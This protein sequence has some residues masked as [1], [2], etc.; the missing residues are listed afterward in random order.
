MKD[1]GLKVHFGRRDGIL[2]GEANFNQE[3][4]IG[5]RSITGSLDKG[6]PRKEIIFVEHE[7]ELIKFLLGGLD[8]F[9]H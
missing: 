7:K 8:C 1:L 5:V 6:L 4:M 9:F 3:D 2:G